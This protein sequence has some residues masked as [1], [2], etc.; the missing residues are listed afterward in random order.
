MFLACA[1]TLPRAVPP[2]REWRLLI[3]SSRLALSAVGQ[4]YNY[5]NECPVSAKGCAMKP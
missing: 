5:G 4:A 3:R 2:L 1:R